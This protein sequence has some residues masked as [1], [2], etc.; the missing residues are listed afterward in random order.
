MKLTA[1]WSEGMHRYC[2]LSSSLS[3]LLNSFGH[4]WSLDK[5]ILHSFA[6]GLSSCVSSLLN[7][8]CSRTW[9]VQGFHL[10]KEGVCIP[11]NSLSCGLHEFHL[12]NQWQMYNYE[13]MFI[14]HSI[15]M[16]GLFLLEI[17]R[18]F[19]TAC[20]V[21]KH[22]PSGVISPANLPASQDSGFNLLAQPFLVE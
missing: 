4:V 2:L 10:G 13:P 21:A 16:S 1:T 6:P 12:F 5:I 9:H 20:E 17:W 14:Q 11:G 19:C 15:Q 7:F 8:R 18:T 22:K 3:S